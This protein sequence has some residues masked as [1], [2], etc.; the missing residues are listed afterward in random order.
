VTD[1]DRFKLLGKYHTPRFRYGQ[2]VFCEVR[3]WVVI[4]GLTQA[5][6]PWPVCKKR[7]RSTGR[8][9]LLVY[10]GLARAL[11]RESEQAACHWWGVCPTAVWKWRKALG[12][13]RTQTEGTLQ[14]R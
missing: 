8:T 2:V 5:P 4:T 1:A 10:Q 12:I 11:R 9:S 13:A 3:G 14:L 7:G 6:L